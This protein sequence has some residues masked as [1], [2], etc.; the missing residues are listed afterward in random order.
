VLLRQKSICDHQC[1]HARENGEGF[2]DHRPL[3]RSR[4]TGLRFRPSFDFALCR[5][6]ASLTLGSVIDATEKLTGC[7]IERAYVEKG[8]R[9]HDTANPHRVSISGQKRGVFGV[10]KR[11]LRRRSAIEPVIGHMKSDGHAA[12]SKAKRRRRKCHPHRRG[13]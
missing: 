4:Q 7:A 2:S 13:L 11:E 3:A 10:I 12:I 9:G 1:H 5:W 8:Y 6:C